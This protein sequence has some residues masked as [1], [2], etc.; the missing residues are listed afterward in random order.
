MKVRYNKLTVT[1]D[2]EFALVE[3]R[4]AQNVLLAMVLE[5]TR[6]DALER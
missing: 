1:Y 5:V 2:S 4:C 6:N 3:T